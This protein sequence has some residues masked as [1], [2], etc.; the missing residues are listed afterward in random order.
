MP[1]ADAEN[2]IARLSGGLHPAD[3]DAFRRSAEAAINSPGQ[4]WGEG[5][6]HRTVVAVWRDYF[7]LPTD[8]PRT[9]TWEQGRRAASN[10]VAKPACEDNGYP[11]RRIG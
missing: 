9:T 8:E 7:H 1:S 6:I 3:R 11:V 2:L 5:L 10:L 4:C